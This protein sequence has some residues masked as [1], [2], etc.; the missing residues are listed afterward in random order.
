MRRF[1]HELSPES[2]R[3]RFFTAGEPPDGW[4][5]G[6][7]TRRTNSA[8]SRWSRCARSATTRGSSPS[9]PTS[10][11]A[12]R[13]RS[14]VRRRRS[15]SGQ[16]PRRPSC[17]S[18]SPRSPPATAS[19]ASRRRRSPTTHAMLE[20]FRDSGFEVRSKS[21]GGVRRR[22]LTLTPSAEGVVVGR[23]A[24]APGDGGVAAADA[25]AARRRRRRRLARSRRASAGGFSTRSSPAGFSGPIYP[26][27]PARRRSRRPARVSLGARRCRPA[28]ISPS[29]P[30]RATACSPSSTTAPRPA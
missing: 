4:S 29:S 30:C 11:P 16:G 2:R 18:G 21:A 14:G 9:A 7:A 23:D 28:S 17:S 5:I 3:Q 20:V 8:A 26:V 10:R 12:G 15:L 13:R 22:Q 27:N 19:A 1:F 6:C 25:R 24:P